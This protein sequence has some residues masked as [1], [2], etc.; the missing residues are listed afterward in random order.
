MEPPRPPRPRTDC[1]KGGAP[2]PGARSYGMSH[3]PAVLRVAALAAA[4]LLMPATAFAQEPS[5]APAPPSPAAVVDAPS[6]AAAPVRIFAADGTELA[7][8]TLVDRLEPAEVIFLGEFHDDAVAHAQQARIFEALHRRAEGRRPVVLSLEMFETDIQGVVDEYLAGLITEDHFLQ[9]SRPWGRYAEDYRPLVE[10]AREH[11][12]RV[13]AA[14]PARR[15]VNRVSREGPE[16]LSAL[17]ESA[18]RTLP[19][20]PYAPPSDAYRREWDALMGGAG[21][22]GT[23]GAPSQPE[24]PA[25]SIAPLSSAASAEGE[26]PEREVEAVLPP[27]SRGLWAQTLWDAGMAWSIASALGTPAAGDATG[28]QIV[29]LAGAFH[30]QNGTGIPEHL[31]GYRPGTRALTVVFV[32]SPLEGEWDAATQGGL[33]DFVVWTG[34]RPEAPSP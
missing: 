31:E 34:E 4:L 13:V 10:Y 33:G 9:S 32:P 25:D 1:G 30:V 16:S 11:G 12:L 21:R 2:N 23:P 5:P 15:Y 18:L 17:P 22:G 28:P 26:H 7:F 20:L 14:N 19:P 8:E 29:H 3:P 6:P 27:V 24:G